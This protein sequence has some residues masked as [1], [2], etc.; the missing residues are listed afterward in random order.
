MNLRFFGLY[1]AVSDRFTW[2]L[3]FVVTYSTL[4]LCTSSINSLLCVCAPF[5]LLLYF[6]FSLAAVHLCNRARFSSQPFRI[7]LLSGLWSRWPRTLYFRYLRSDE[8]HAARSLNEIFTYE[9]INKSRQCTP[10]FHACLTF[11]KRTRTVV[12]RLILTLGPRARTHALIRN[13]LCS[14]LTLALRTNSLGRERYALSSSRPSILRRCHSKMIISVQRIFR[15][16]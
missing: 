10:D 3:R 9:K 11:I 2:T 8:F 5:P 13:V 14:S 4:R 15:N 7:W 1:A 6:F 16:I 12:L